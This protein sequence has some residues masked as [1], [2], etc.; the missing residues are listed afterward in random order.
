MAV[1]TNR[2]EK[3]VQRIRE[4][5]GEACQRARRHPDEVGI[6]AVTKSADID[7]IKNLLDAGLTE[8]GESRGQSLASRA[9][10]I[11]AYLQRRRTPLPAPVRWHM[12]GHLQRNKVK[13][14]LPVVTAIHSVDSLRLAEELQD[15]AG[16]MDR[17]VDV[18]LQVNCS[19]EEQKYGCAVGA[20][21]HLGE[22]IASLEN[23]RLVGLMTMGP[24]TDD[25]N[26]SRMAFARCR[27]LFEEMRGERVGDDHFRH[28]SMGMSS[29]YV[30]AV[31][32][33]ATLLR[34][35]TALFE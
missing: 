18:F 32:E 10:E 6:I 30:P 8:L 35:G 13:S 26:E 29:D 7:T 15:R 27:E 20:V 21:F 2:I 22:M 24:L 19:N 31:E 12:V 34:I 4:E 5:I 25:P 9:E 16:R 11:H 14:V 23:I 28:L 3:N 17:R 33:G 1:T